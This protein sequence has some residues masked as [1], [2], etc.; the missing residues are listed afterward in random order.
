MRATLYKVATPI[1]VRRFC[2]G[3]AAVISSSGRMKYSEYRDLFQRLREPRDIEMLGK[4]TGHDP[5][6]LMVIYTQRVTRDATKKF[7]KVKRHSKKLHWMWKQGRS[8]VDIAREYEFPPVL[9]A[10]MIL[11][12]DKVSRK[13]FWRYLSDLDNVEDIKLHRDLKE[14]TEA[15]IVYSPQG[16]ARQY[17]RGRWGEKKLQ[18]WLDRYGIPYRTENQVRHQFEKT[19]DTVLGEPL[20]F[21]G[22]KITWIESKATFGDPLEVR[23]HVARQLKPY[24]EIF[25]DGIVVYWFGYVEDAD[26]QLPEGVIIA[27]DQFFSEDG[28]GRLALPLTLRGEG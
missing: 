6:L 2:G 19:P 13:Q 25:G 21:N 15:D 11:E 26:L 4:E 23:R 16:T 12:E 8:F 9:T 22:S 18:D 24:A 10:L 14:A 1:R 3:D 5:E 27:N 17:A 28:P 20:E 7:Y